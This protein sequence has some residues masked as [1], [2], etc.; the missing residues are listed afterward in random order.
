MIE[1]EPELQAEV[2]AKLTL[3]RVVPTPPTQGVTSLQ[4]FAA[5]TCNKFLKIEHQCL[6]VFE[7]IG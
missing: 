1:R 6:I 7:N 5:E 4:L 3:L 2:L